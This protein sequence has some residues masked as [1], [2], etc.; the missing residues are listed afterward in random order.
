MFRIMPRSSNGM[1]IQ[2]YLMRDLLCVNH[3]PLNVKFRLGFTYSITHWEL[4]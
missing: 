1:K 3:H 2:R 4:M